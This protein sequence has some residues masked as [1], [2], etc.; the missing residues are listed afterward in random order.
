MEWIKK[1]DLSLDKKI[2]IATIVKKYKI[3]NTSFIQ[4]NIYI[5]LENSQTIILKNSTKSLY[6][7]INKTLED[8]FEK[9]YCKTKKKIAIYWTQEE[10]EYL[11]KNFKGNDLISLSISLNK[12]KY[13]IS[14]KAIELGLLVRKEWSLEEI[15]YLKKNIDLSNYILAEK[16]DRSIFSIKSKK[17]VLKNLYSY[18]NK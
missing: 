18:L 13:Q 6:D 10:I 4:N 12:S 16:L 8:F 17:R 7:E 1:L 5:F 2:K 14:S 9:K 11:K 15:E 3:L